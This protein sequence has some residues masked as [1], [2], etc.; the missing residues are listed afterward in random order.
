M[1]LSEELK[2][3]LAN[4]YSSLRV[5]SK[6]LFPVRFDRP[7]SAL[8]NRIFKAL[9]DKSIQKIVIKAPRGVG[10]TSIAQLSFMGR[11]ILFQEQ[12][13]I[14]PI[15]NTATQ[16]IM[17]SENLKLELR[18]N[19]DIRKLFGDVKDSRVDESLG[20]DPAFSKEMWIANGKTLVLPRGSGQQVRGILFKNR[21]PGLIICDDLEDS[22][23]VKNEEQRKKLK[24]WF[25][26][27][28]I[29]SVDRGRNDWRI[30]YIG[31]LLHE[32][33]LLQN[34]IDDPTW[35]HIELDLCDDEYTSLWPEF[36]PTSEIIKMVESYKLQ[37]ELDTFYREY[38]GQAI[39]KE[40]AT[41]LASYFK[42][43]D[44]TK[45]LPFDKSMIENVVIMDPA[46]TTKL[47]S[48]ESAIAGIGIDLIKGGI[49]LRDLVAKKLHPDGLYNET[50]NMADRLKARVIAFEVTSLNEF[51]SFPIRNEMIRRGKLYELIELNAR[52]KKE[53]RI[54][55]L[56]PLYRQGL[57]WHNKNVSG[58]LE[59][60]LLS[61]PRSKRFD[62]MDAVA[63]VIELMEQG[64]RYFF[65]KMETPGGVEQGKTDQLAVDEYADLRA[66]DDYDIEG[67][68]V[69]N[70]GAWRRI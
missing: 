29:N 38:R 28:L 65:P 7:F 41:F 46:K 68:E 24:Q 4:C 64:D 13:F 39:S 66:M 42:W 10:K 22:E 51:I 20:I 3:L 18:S 37:G 33:S 9:D 2:D 55:A 25:F 40:D 70:S 35:V 53:D 5:C 48:A 67:D 62:C 45:D 56:V 30:I 6:V 50:F 69:V 8:H 60:Q 27:D 36:I 21:R 57:I 32:D 1:E 31:T 63:Y 17:Q 44:E 23:G 49:F 52:G 16:A 43:Y 14:V 59:A 54:A 15:S 58:P 11:E 26:S 19:T 47:H 61:F 34:L 12:D